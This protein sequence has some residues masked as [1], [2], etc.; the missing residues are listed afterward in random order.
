MSTL[1]IVATPIGNL[2]DITLRAV[3][4]LGEADVVFAEDTREAKKLLSH[5]DI[6]T[7]VERYDEHSH[8]RQTEKVLAYLADGNDVAL[9]TDAGT[10]GIS[11]PGARLVRAARTAGHT[12]MP[13]P[14][15]SALITA[16][17]ASGISADEFVFLGFPPHKKGRKTFFENIAEEKRAVVLYE[18]PHRI[19]KT[20]E[21]L[22]HTL[23]VNREIVV[24]RELT[25]MY[26]AFVSGTAE[27]VLKYFTENPD[28]VRG[29]FI[30]IVTSK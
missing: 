3:R 30:V 22:A 23:A 15:P 12:I 2:E 25:K 16:L 20:L 17:S 21:A 9:I 8:E 6:T 13:I 18:S 28:K 1:Y 10:P 7:P 19:M 24:A 11:D 26:E 27:E 4:V 29:E 5:F 14:G